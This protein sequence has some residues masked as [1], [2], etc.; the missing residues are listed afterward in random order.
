MPLAEIEREH[1]ANPIQGKIGPGDVRRFTEA[2]RFH[3]R[4][5]FDIATLLLVEDGPGEEEV[6]TLL[7]T[8][9][10]GVPA[11]L[12]GLLEADVSLDR[13]ECLALGKAGVQ[14]AAQLA[15]ADADLLERAL[16]RERAKEILKRR[17]A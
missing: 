13:G 11:S 5:A 15:T 8:L 6:E 10:T 3:L 4:S 9:E 12:H 16:G 14:T 7:K 2:T 1:T 17:A